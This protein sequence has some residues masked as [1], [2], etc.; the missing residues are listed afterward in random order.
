M[1]VG[2]GGGARALG[3]VGMAERVRARGAREGQAA[4]A[5]A[6]ARARRAAP[7]QRTCSGISSLSFSTIAAPCSAVHLPI[8]LP[9]PIAAYCSLMRGERRVLTKDPTARC[10][11]PPPSWMISLSLNRRFKKGCTPSSAPSSVEGPPMFSITTP[12]GRAEGVKD[13]AE[14]RW[15]VAR[16]V[17]EGWRQR[18]A[19]RVFCF[20][21]FVCLAPVSVG[22]RL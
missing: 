1:G 21:F 19:G 16:I 5:S 6:R 10:S 15:R 13:A 7:R 18:P 22:V 12:T 4:Q 8:G 9:P 20:F 11:K 2:V 17:G 14:K 3:V